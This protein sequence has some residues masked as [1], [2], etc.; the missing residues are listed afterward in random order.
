MNYPNGSIGEFGS[1]PL[2]GGMY[3][4]DYVF[5]DGNAVI[6]ENGLPQIMMKTPQQYAEDTPI[7]NMY[8]GQVSDTMHTV[9]RI[10][11]YIIIPHAMCNDIIIHKL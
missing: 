2:A 6:E 3:Y 7:R 1:G 5:Q 9:I 11:S 8:L 4:I 10:V